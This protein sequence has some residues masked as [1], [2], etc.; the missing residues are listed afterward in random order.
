MFIL[1]AFK[2]ESLIRINRGIKLV[3]VISLLGASLFAQNIPVSEHTVPLL[4]NDLPE[5]SSVNDSSNSLA[6]IGRWGYGL[7]YASFIQDKYAYIGNGAVLSIRDYKSKKTLNEVL[8]ERV[9][10]TIYANENLLFVGD[11]KDALHLFDISIAD[12]PVKLSTLFVPGGSSDNRIRDMQVYNGYLYVSVLD[13]GILIFDVSDPVAPSIIATIETPFPC[14]RFA[15]RDSIIY[16]SGRNRGL[17]VYDISD[18]V[19]PF[20][21]DDLQLGPNHSTA[22]YDVYVYKSY[23]LLA[24]GGS[25][26]NIVNIANPDS[27][28]FVTRFSSTAKSFSGEYNR[29]FIVDG[30]KGVDICNILFLPELHWIG[31][32][33]KKYSTT[34]AYVADNVLVTT[35]PYWGSKI[36]DVRYISDLKIIDSL[37]TG[38]IARRIAVRD[39][40][41]FVTNGQAGV[42]IVDVKDP[43]H[44]ERISRIKSRDFCWDV[45]IDSNFAFVTDYRAGISI[46]NIEDMYNPVEVARIET[47]KNIDS[48][49]IVARET[50]IKD[51]YLYIADA[52]SG[53]R[54]FDISTA[55]NPVEIGSNS[56][57]RGLV[58]IF[59]KDIGLFVRKRLAFTARGKRITAFDVDD[60]GNPSFYRLA[61]Y[62]ETK[63]YQ[64]QVVAD[65]NYAYYACDYSGVEIIP[66]QSSSNHK[67]FLTGG[68][69]KGLCLE[70]NTLYVANGI[71]GV[72]VYDVK[73]KEK[74]KKTGYYVGGDKALGITVRDQYIYVADNEAG[75]YIL[76]QNQQNL[77]TENK[78]FVLYQNYP[79]P[80]NAGTTIPFYVKRSAV[81]T[82]DLYNILGKRI[83]RIT[84][85]NYY[86]GYYQ[87][88]WDGLNE[89]GT[90]ASSGLFFVRIFSDD[91]LQSTKKIVLIR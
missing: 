3:L 44:P 24:S 40:F 62:R 18:P 1:F 13:S 88:Q 50:F 65:E 31:H 32:I 54:I 83:R 86:P 63:G 14:E 61:L 82:I 76:K 66:L 21:R 16:I 6:L 72:V 69:A 43:A 46:Y 81:L 51:N 89:D 2:Y 90:P 7:N 30:D 26:L 53:L 41:L 68:P 74:I 58:S 9:I 73:N 56:Q 47:Y 36:Y 4:A 75:F 55:Q 27:V 77:A 64:Q 49:D 35:D 28:Y 60:P 85:A 10:T 48:D 34:D 45:D 37:R 78:T 84:K 80:F 23:A 39:S 79:N 70:E 20:Y 25:G 33:E 52:R 67:Q 59:V 17:F 22:V 57:Y 42:F 11:K 5:T 38:G 12:Q 15:I 19:H 91:A 71:S 87:L 8:M 29:L